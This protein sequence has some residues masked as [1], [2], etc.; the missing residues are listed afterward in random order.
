MF[1]CLL[2]HIHSSED[3]VDRLGINQECFQSRVSTRELDISKF[4]FNIQFQMYAP[5]RS[6]RMILHTRLGQP[7]RDN[8]PQSDTKGI[9]NDPVSQTRTCQRTGLLS[10]YPKRCSQSKLKYSH[11]SS[12]R[13]DI[14]ICTNGTNR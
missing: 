3:E 14:G 1:Q 7:T 9:E 13:T 5:E 2:A 8:F 4:I 12:S 6:P 10:R 11:R